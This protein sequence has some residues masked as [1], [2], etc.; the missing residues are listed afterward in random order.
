MNCTQRFA[1]KGGTLATVLIALTLATIVSCTEV[2]N[3][4]VIVIDT[5]A[6]STIRDTLKCEK[7]DD[8]HHECRHR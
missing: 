5:T 8:R 6:D 7:D 3:V 2:T 1:M 4:T